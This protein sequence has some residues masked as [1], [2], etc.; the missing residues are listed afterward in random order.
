MKITKIVQDSES[1]EIGI[2]VKEDEEYDI[3]EHLQLLTE[4]ASEQGVKTHELKKTQDGLVARL[5]KCEEE[6][7]KLIEKFKVD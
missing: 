4:F 2:Q 3:E 5:G 1:G 7:S 6:L